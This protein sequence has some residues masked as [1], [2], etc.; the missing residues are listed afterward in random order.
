[1]ISNHPLEGVR[2]TGRIPNQM[3]AKEEMTSLRRAVKKQARL[4]AKEDQK[5]FEGQSV[6]LVSSGLPC[7]L[8]GSFSIFNSN[9][10][11]YLHFM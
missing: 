11:L 3:I 4:A 1:M 6:N 8:A 5:V 10:H 7:L 2:C 9:D